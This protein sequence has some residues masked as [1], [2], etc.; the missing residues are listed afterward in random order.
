MNEN[1][2]EARGVLRASAPPPPCARHSQLVRVRVT[3]IVRS[4]KVPSSV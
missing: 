2:A 4:Q 3:L 1:E